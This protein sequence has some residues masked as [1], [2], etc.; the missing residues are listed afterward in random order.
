MNFSIS[1][2][3]SS[4]LI[5]GLRIYALLVPIAS[6]LSLS[7]GEMVIN[8]ATAADGYVCGPTATAG[9]ACI[10]AGNKRGTCPGPNSTC[11]PEIPLALIPMFLLVSAASFYY[12]RRRQLNL[13]I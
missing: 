13:A 6:L 10:M 9:E 11:A 7:I 12:I 5:R 8:T 4:R 3:I 2:K 1:K